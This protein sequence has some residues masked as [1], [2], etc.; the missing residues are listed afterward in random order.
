GGDD[1]HD[2]IA[3]A[4]ILAKVTR[5]QE[6][7]ELDAVLPQYGFAQHK[8]YPTKQH[9]EALI[10]HGACHLH[11]RSFKPVSDAIAA[12]PETGFE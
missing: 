3:A 5:D 6:M 7:S 10:Q 9:R 11:R 1:L 2:C 4:S 12:H 8:G